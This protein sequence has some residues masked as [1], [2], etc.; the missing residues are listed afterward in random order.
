[1]RDSWILP[2]RNI[3]YLCYPIILWMFGIGSL[4]SQACSGMNA[5]ISELEAGFFPQNLLDDRTGVQ[6]GGNP[7]SILSR[8][9]DLS[10]DPDP[11]TPA[12]IRF[13]IFSKQ[14]DTEEWITPAELENHPDIIRGEEGRPLLAGTGEDGMINIGQRA[15]WELPFGQPV[16]VRLWF[17]PVTVHNVNAGDFESVFEDSC[18]HLNSQDPVSI[19]FIR[20]IRLE[21][22]LNYWDRNTNEIIIPVSGGLPEIDPDRFQYE[23]EVT[24]CETKEKIPLEK[25]GFNLFVFQMDKLYGEYNILTTD[26]FSPKHLLTCFPFT[27]PPVRLSIP[28]Q[29]V[30]P[31]EEF[32]MPVTVT[33]FDDIDS[34]SFS[35]QWDEEVVEFTG[36]GPLGYSH[37]EL[38]KGTGPGFHRLS[39]REGGR[40]VWE[41]RGESITI[42]DGDTLFHLCFQATGNPGSRTP[43]DSW[44]EDHRFY[45][46]ALFMP[47]RIEEGRVTIIR[48]DHIGFSYEVL[49][50]PAASGPVDIMMEITGKNPPFTV[51]FDPEDT[52]DRIIS[53]SRDTLYDIPRG[54]YDVTVTDASGGKI[55]RVNQEFVTRFEGNFRVR[56]D[57]VRSHDP[58]CHGDTDGEIYVDVHHSQSLDY[59]IFY[60]KGGD[61]INADQPLIKDLDAGEYTIW[62]V[63]QRGC[64]AHLPEPVIL[65]D[66][67]P[68]TVLQENVYLDCGKTDT[69]ISFENYLDGGT[70]VVQYAFGDDPVFHHPDRDTLLREG[71]YMLHMRDF[72]GCEATSEFSVLGGASDITF[73][74]DHP[75]DTLFA[76]PD[77]PFEMTVT[78]S[79]SDADL[80]YQWDAR[81]GSLVESHQDEARFSFQEDGTVLLTIVDPF[82]CVYSDELP[83]MILADKEGPEKEGCTVSLPNAIVPHGENHTLR[84]Y[85]TCE[86]GVQEIRIYDRW[87]GQRYAGQEEEVGYEVWERLPPDVY[88]V[89]VIYEQSGRGVRKMTEAVMVVK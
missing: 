53:G 34:F 40:F 68:L 17:V 47:P 49:S 16:P 38:R 20:H 67:A 81:D 37:P 2:C 63:D 69:L 70:G 21:L 80:D 31:N 22:G 26:K 50:C 77:E 32:C 85:A 76:D 8:N 11:A 57:S 89:E 72:L 79:S 75:D 25:K 60:Q 36:F 48:E 19:Y 13:L 44:G 28:H 41:T 88:L 7:F 4:Y 56:V 71:T 30:Y 74:F 58:L 35:L 62:V 87:G 61:T 5:G 83:V 29:E 86:I 52:E 3:K 65:K 55:T 78:V 42:P 24:D 23:V 66:P 33:N 64:E 82:G 73:T 39:N 1:M 27:K 54:T 59:S 9:F 84:V 12:G 15:P 14:P 45:E 51:S 18:I 6:V 46:G 43:V 10:D